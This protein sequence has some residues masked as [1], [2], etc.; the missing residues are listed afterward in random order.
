MQ[1]LGGRNLENAKLEALKSFFGYDSFRDGQEEIIDAVL[2]GRDVMAVMPTGAGK[3]ICYQLPALM[4]DGVTIVISPLISLMKDQV[5]SLVQSGV[6][7]A[8]LNSSLTYAQMN[9][10]ESNMRQGMYK[11]IYAA[12]ERLAV[13]SFIEACSHLNI[14]MVTVDEAHCVS[15]WGQDFR[16]SYL[17][18]AEFIE[19]LPKRPVTAAFTATATSIVREDI[20]RCLRLSDPFSLTTGFDREN[21]RFEV[22]NVRPSDKYEEMKTVIA[23]YPESSG[24]VYCSSRKNVEEVCR[25]LREEGYSA[26]RYHAGLTDEERRTAQEDFIYDRV[27][28][29][30]ATN[31]FGMGID[32]PDVAYVIHYN[33]PKDIE[34]YYQEAGRA[35]R[36]GSDAECVL[37]FSSQDIVTAK[38]LIDMPNENPEITPEEAEAVRKRAHDRLNVMAD[39]AKTTGC[40]RKYILNYFGEDAPDCCG[41]CSS[42]TGKRV[43]TD[44]TV[45]AQKIMS[46]IARTGQRFGKGMVFNVLRGS[47]SEKVTERGFEKLSVYGIMK[48]CSRDRMNFYLTV[49]EEN[50]LVRPTDDEYAILKITA[51]GAAVLKGAVRFEAD[52]PEAMADPEKAEK[53]RSRD[54]IRTE[55]PVDEDLLA[56]LRAKRAELAA[57]QS[58]PAYVI[59]GNA[60][61]ISMCRI[62]PRTPEEMRSVSGVGSVKLERY[63]E[64]FLGI[65]ND[66]LNGVPMPEKAVSMPQS[67]KRDIMRRLERELSVPEN[68]ADNIYRRGLSTTV[69]KSTEILQEAF[70]ELYFKRDLLTASDEGAGAKDFM[71][72]IAEEAN[73]DISVGKAASA[74]IDLLARTGYIK[75]ERDGSGRVRY[76]ESESSGT[77]EISFRDV[78]LKSGEHYRKMLLGRAAQEFIL[79]ELGQLA[80]YP[81]GEK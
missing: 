35:G 50:G 6:R 75:R 4:S 38:Y 11:I 37:L 2:S 29:M 46:C 14:T 55:Y 79:S 61:L 76:S 17:K 24:I 65:I 30:A 51:D 69:T 7:A 81:I 49:M 12:P 45:P 60:A 80:L 44:L 15:Q 47:R 56:K 70:A 40:L 16:P 52:I 5:T 39:Y 74:V 26:A 57:V 58:V 53:S 25:R 59:F 66:H 42:C 31:A 22:R 1:D 23:K 10:A 36:D 41:N 43:R 67:E 3:S 62:L 54:R 63:G 77:L 72:R 20:I 27:K 28:I 78:E 64:I 21:L 71:M 33:M 19:N 13:P 32:K 68:T 8:F 9:R 73:S 48:D 18:I 34:S